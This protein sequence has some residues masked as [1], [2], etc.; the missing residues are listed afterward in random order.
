MCA[1]EANELL[2]EMGDA[3]EADKLLLEMDK[4]RCLCATEADKLP[5]NLENTVE[6]NKLL[7]D[8]D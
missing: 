2:P 7:L 1:T 4:L 3:M 5:P 6:S 8:L